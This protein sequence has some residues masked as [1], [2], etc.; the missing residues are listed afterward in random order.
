[1]ADNTEK[2]VLIDV[3]IKSTEALKNLAQLKIQIDDLKENQD[4]LKK[5]M[6]STNTSTKEGA[7]TYERIRQE[8]EKVGQ[9]I[10]ALNAR[11]NEYQKT[12][13]N[14]VKYEYEQEGSLQQLKAQLSLNTAAHNKLSESERNS[15]E[16]DVFKKQIVETTEKLKQAEQELGNFR[17]SVGDYSIAGKEL[18]NELKE[19]TSQMIVLAECGQ[20]T[21]KNMLM[22]QPKRQN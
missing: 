12:I 1:M 21:V 8:Y 7:E 5:A 13:Q 3:E 20:K 18:K 10:K 22:R 2:K 11:A 6:E 15:A 16:G 19:L 4:V 14:N 9:E 17:R